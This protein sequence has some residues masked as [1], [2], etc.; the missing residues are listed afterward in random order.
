MSSSA[1]IEQLEA[2]LAALKAGS[3]ASAFP[4][5][6]GVVFKKLLADSG[7]AKVYRA[8][9]ERQDVAAKVFHVDGAA[10]KSFRSEIASLL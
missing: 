7:Q 4:V 5:Y 3:A 1:S 8:E 6:D 10:L 2:Q 9:F